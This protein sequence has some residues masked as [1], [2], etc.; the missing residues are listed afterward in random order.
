MRLN[1]ILKEGK[2]KREFEEPADAYSGDA[3]TH[4][5]TD[6]DQFHLIMHYHNLY[7]CAETTAL[8]QGQALGNFRDRLKVDFK[9]RNVSAKYMPSVADIKNKVKAYSAEE[10][11]DYRS[12]LPPSYIRDI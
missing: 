6:R 5:D 9:K 8:S 3:S 4:N 11:N 2:W 1:D 10:Y 7:F 12:T